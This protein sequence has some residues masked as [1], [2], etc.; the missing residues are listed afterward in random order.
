MQFLRQKF[1]VCT[2]DITGITY[3]LTITMFSSE[4]DE[5]F[6]VSEDLEGL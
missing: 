5:T 2:P 6:K 3:D 4:P 1:H